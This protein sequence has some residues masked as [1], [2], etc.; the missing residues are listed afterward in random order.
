MRA[1]LQHPFYEG[2][3][4]D[5]LR[6]SFHCFIDQIEHHELMMSDGD[7]RILDFLVQRAIETRGQSGTLLA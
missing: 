4:T 3:D 1:Y 6:I 5:F 7:G 2:Y